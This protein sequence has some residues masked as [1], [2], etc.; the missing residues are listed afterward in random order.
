VEGGRWKIEGRKWRVEWKMEAGSAK[1]TM[2]WKVEHRR[3][4][5]KVGFLLSTFHFP[6]STFQQWIWYNELAPIKL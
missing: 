2:E 1:L 5:W 3:W 4:K 6:C